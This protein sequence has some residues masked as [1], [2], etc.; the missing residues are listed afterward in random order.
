VLETYE[1]REAWS[2]SQQFIKSTF[3]DSV[4]S[5]VLTLSRG[6]LSKA[7]NILLV[8]VGNDQ[9]LLRKTAI[10]MFIMQ[11]SQESNSHAL[12]SQIKFK[13]PYS[14]LEIFLLPWNANRLQEKKKKKDSFD[15]AA[16]GRWS[17][18]RLHLQTYLTMIM[19]L[20]NPNLFPSLDQPAEKPEAIDCEKEWS[21]M[22]R[23]GSAKLLTSVQAL[24]ANISNFPD[25]SDDN[26]SARPE[27]ERSEDEEQV[28]NV[29]SSR[30]HPRPATVPETLSTELQKTTSEQKKTEGGTEHDMQ[31]SVHG[32]KAVEGEIVQVLSQQLLESPELNLPG[33]TPMA[34]PLASGTRGDT[35]TVPPNCALELMKQTLS[36]ILDSMNKFKTFS[37]KNHVIVSLLRCELIEKAKSLHLA[38]SS[39]V[40]LLA[41]I[42]MDTGISILKSVHNRFKFHRYMNMDTADLA[43]QFLEK[44]VA[45]QNSII[46][47]LPGDCRADSGVKNAVLLALGLWAM[48]EAPKTGALGEIQTT[49]QERFKNIVL[50]LLPWAQ[51]P[52]P[53]MSLERTDL[54][55][56]LSL[57]L[58]NGCTK[59]NLWEAFAQSIEPWRYGYI[60]VLQFPNAFSHDGMALIKGGM[61]IQHPGVS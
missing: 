3:V 59:I 9:M 23:G 1:N 39:E 50:R 44:Y 60:Y 46:D 18:M 28:A 32:H 33:P 21:V 52:W 30:E 5:P 19:R 2:A 4:L 58:Q 54:R 7:V 61:S 17:T 42:L 8:N 22:Y 49:A 41:N 25:D 48:Q 14:D 11:L 36:A 27:E 40:M 24:L 38:L 10:A 45:E 20:S 6:D 16:K 12:C 35:R 29:K 55:S 34:T 37:E 47:M 43:S 57:T 53:N 15:R 51:Y 13:R 56:R 26:D 31:R